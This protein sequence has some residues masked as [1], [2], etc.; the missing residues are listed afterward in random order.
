MARFLAIGECMLEFAPSKGG[1][2]AKGYAGDTFNTAWY[3]RRLA[4]PNVKVGF[5]SAVGDDEASIEMTEF[6]KSAGVDP[7][8]A[9]RPNISVGLYMISLDNGE[10]SFSY[11]R[12]HSAARTLADDLSSL[13]V[14]TGD[15]V[16]F[17]GITMAILPDTGKERLLAALATARASGVTDCV[18][19]GIRPVI[20]TTSGHLDRGIRPPSV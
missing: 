3:A 19:R 14:S 13:P 5:L 11:W 4:A 10:R 8:L 1:L 20:P 7:L 9:V 18:F 6:I 17:S 16:Y 15:T 2:F 12:G